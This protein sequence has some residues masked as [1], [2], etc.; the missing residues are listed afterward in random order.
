MSVFLNSNNTSLYGQQ[1]YKKYINESCDIS[2]N[3]PSEWKLEEKRD[4]D[5]TRPVN[6]IVEFQPNNGDGGKSVVGIELDDISHL[7]DRSIESM[8]MN[9][10]TI[11]TGQRT[12]T[13]ETSQTI[14]VAGH[15]AQKI[16]YTEPGINDEILKKMQVDVLAFNREY[17]I[18]FD[19]ANAELF[20]KYI[21]TVE[22]M[23][24]T[25]E[26]SEP[27]YEEISC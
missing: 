23:V 7:P 17:K 24:K 27:T 10:E 2:I 16:V 15:E 3:Y 6:Y 1:A 11:I 20:Q 19:T 18:T 4:D 14:N 25:F 9:E 12:G 8:K 21:S 22:E 5:A 26:I 13:I